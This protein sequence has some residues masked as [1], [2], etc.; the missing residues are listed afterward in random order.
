[1]GSSSQ[2][3]QAL[4]IRLL[5]GNPTEG[6]LAFDLNSQVTNNGQSSYSQ[7]LVH[8]GVIAQAS[9]RVASVNNDATLDLLIITADSNVHINVEFSCGGDFF[10]SI[11][12]GVTASD[13]GTG[14]TLYNTN[15]QAT[16]TYTTTVFHTPTVSDTGTEIRSLYIPGG[17]G[18]NSIGNSDGELARSPEVILKKNTKYLYRATNKAGSAKP[19]S[20]QL[21]LYEKI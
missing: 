13:N 3:Q 2:E 6:N 8:N 20:F 17:T 5:G 10:L 4:L 15:R 19:M 21:G 9:Y 12:E 11:Y 18:G 14:L 16:T 1:M 7:Q